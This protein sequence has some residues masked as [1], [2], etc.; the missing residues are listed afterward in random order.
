[1]LT[2][3]QSSVV[4][5]TRAIFKR[6][7]LGGRRITKADLSMR[8]MGATGDAQNHRCQ[9]QWRL[10]QGSQDKR[11]SGKIKGW[12]VEEECGIEDQRIPL[13]KKKKR[14]RRWTSRGQTWGGGGG[15]R[16]GGGRE[17]GRAVIGRRRHNL[18]HLTGGRPTGVSRFLCTTQFPPFSTESTW[19]T[20]FVF[21]FSGTRETRSTVRGHLLVA[22]VSIFLPFGLGIDGG[23]EI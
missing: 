4:S 14:E 12:L 1:M 9:P 21:P 18:R 20:L 23:P 15:R 2:A 7:L 6:K 17:G 8:G 11:I 22:V 5:R 10:T 3:R 19:T 16:S 13:R